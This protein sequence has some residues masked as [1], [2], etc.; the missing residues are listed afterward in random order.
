[1]GVTAKINLKIPADFFKPKAYM[2]LEAQKQ[3]KRRK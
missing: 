3:I 2:F 1:M